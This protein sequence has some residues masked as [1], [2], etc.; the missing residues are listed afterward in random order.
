MASRT[1]PH[2]VQAIGI[3][4]DALLV[5]REDLLTPR[6]LAGHGVPQNFWN[7]CSLDANGGTPKDVI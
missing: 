3:M 6:I 4:D 2:D 7:L 5:A 1:P